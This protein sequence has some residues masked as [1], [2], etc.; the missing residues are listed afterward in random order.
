VLVG[1][2]GFVVVTRTALPAFG[3]TELT[4]PAVV[5]V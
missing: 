3:L 1:P 2:E 4:R 5:G